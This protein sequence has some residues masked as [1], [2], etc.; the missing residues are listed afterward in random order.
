MISTGTPSLMHYENGHD[1]H[2]SYNLK[3]SQ[4][5]VLHYQL[6]NGDGLDLNAQTA[7]LH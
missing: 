6:K 7:R 1:G 4:N 3:N 5:L 2:C